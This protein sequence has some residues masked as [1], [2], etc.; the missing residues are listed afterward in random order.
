MTRRFGGPMLR[1][2]RVARPVALVATLVLLGFVAF[3]IISE[4]TP[5]SGTFPSVRA[6][7]ELKR[8]APAP[9]FTAE[10][11]GGGAPV[12]YSGRSKEPV[13]LN[14]FASWCT[15]CV[16]ELDTFS[17][18]SRH[19]S[20]VTFVG[21]D[22][23][24][25]DVANAERLLHRAGITYAIADDSSGVI[26]GRYL[27]AALPVTFFI[28]PDGRIAASVVGRASAAALRAGL[29]RAGGVRR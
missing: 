23:D 2:D 14:F 29:A 1:R 24:D 6:A 26:A 15:N 8:G 13:V 7:S 22:S 21:V 18:V 25:S 28:A 16:A 12:A 17:T 10:R 27:V 9:A 11:L 19:T 5:R 20:G 3:V 4:A